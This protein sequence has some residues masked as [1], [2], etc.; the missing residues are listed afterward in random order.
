MQRKLF[1]K[2]TFE[3]KWDVANTFYRKASI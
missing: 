1:R 3:N 2:Q